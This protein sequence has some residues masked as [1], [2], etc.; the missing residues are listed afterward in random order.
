MA[1]P[2]PRLT[3]DRP[4]AASSSLAAAAGGTDGDEL[5]WRRT[6]TEEGL[7]VRAWGLEKRGGHPGEVGAAVGPR[8]QRTA[9]LLRW[10][11]GSGNGFLLSPCL[12]QQGRKKEKCRGRERENG[13]EGAGP[14]LKHGK[15]AARARQV[16]AE[17]SAG[18]PRGANSQ[19]GD[20]TVHKI[21]IFNSTSTIPLK[22]IFRASVTLKPRRVSKNSIYKSCRS[23][24]HLQLFLKR[25]SLIRSGWR[26]TRL[27]RRVNEN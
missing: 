18:E 19:Q 21:Q 15:V 8:N 27:Q 11:C 14:G 17:C 10:I 23:T 12:A 22:L 26:D 24:R 2:R 16:A 20:D 9:W 1:N 3:L 4:A 13:E 5:W 6:T 25:Q 7:P